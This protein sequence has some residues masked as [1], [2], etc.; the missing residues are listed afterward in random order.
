M[1]RKIPTD[2]RCL[3]QYTQNHFYNNVL[4]LFGFVSVCQIYVRDSLEIAETVFLQVHQK[5]S[6]CPTHY[7][8][9][10]TF[11]I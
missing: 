9:H 4:G 6:S 3:L 7:W 1:T 8:R 5:S 2:D 10:S 11:I